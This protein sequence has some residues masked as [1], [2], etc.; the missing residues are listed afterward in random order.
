MRSDHLAK[1]IKTHQKGS[2]LNLA[3]SSTDLSNMIMQMEADQSGGATAMGM[4]GFA[5]NSAGMLGMVA[6]E[7]DEMEGDDDDDED[8]DE[9]ESGSEISDSEIAPAV[10]GG[11]IMLP[12]Q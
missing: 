8:D 1:H 5:A 10:G 6:M 9:S 11:G 4:A 2:K 12:G 7:G 3:T